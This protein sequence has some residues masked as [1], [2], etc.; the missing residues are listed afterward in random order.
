MEG[1]D[2]LFNQYWRQS[3]TLEKGKTPLQTKAVTSWRV[4]RQRRLTLSMQQT[5]HFA[6]NKLI[7]VSRKELLLPLIQIKV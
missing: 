3:G 7:S 6:T 1:V 4:K 2:G 5:H